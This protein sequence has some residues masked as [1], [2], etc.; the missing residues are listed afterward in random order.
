MMQNKWI[1]SQQSKQKQN[2]IK[3]EIFTAMFLMQYFCLHGIPSIFQIIP[4]NWKH[5][6]NHKV[7]GKKVFRHVIL[8]S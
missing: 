5:Q 8:H 4:W 6:T 7:E 1:L 2:K 3:I